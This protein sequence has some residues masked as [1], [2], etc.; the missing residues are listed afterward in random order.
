[1]VIS[2]TAIIC[3]VI[4]LYG[5][6]LSSKGSSLAECIA[7]Q[8]IAIKDDKHHKYKVLWEHV[9]IQ[10]AAL[11]YCIPQSPIFIHFKQYEFDTY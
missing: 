4:N 3:M 1:M 2:L 11:Y 5:P 8:N 9:F 7:K 10:V 6:I